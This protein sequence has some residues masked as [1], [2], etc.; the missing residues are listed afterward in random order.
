MKKQDLV[1][2]LIPFKLRRRKYRKYR[3]VKITGFGG[4]DD[5]N[6]VPVNKE[7]GFAV[8]VKP[9][10]I[11]TDEDQVKAFNKFVNVRR[12]EI[13]GLPIDYVFKTNQ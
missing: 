4:D 1:F 8:S 6:V 2:I 3:K 10:Y 11:I 12:R 9:H 5:I 13:E 7:Y